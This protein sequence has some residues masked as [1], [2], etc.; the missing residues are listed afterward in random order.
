MMRL[1]DLKDVIKLVQFGSFQ[2]LLLSLVAQGS[3][4]FFKGELI[5]GGDS[6]LR[7]IIWFLKNRERN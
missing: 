3:S 5:P 7:N 4:L 6:G 2:K 1:A